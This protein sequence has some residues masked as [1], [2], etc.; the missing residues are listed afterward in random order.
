MRPCLH[1]LGWWLPP[2]SVFDGIFFLLG[3]FL[4]EGCHESID[5]QLAGRQGFTSTAVIALHAAYG[6]MGAASQQKVQPT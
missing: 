5:R 2:T 4:L 6:A 1:Q 3:L